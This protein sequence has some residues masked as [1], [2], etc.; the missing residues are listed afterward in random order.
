MLV[1]FRGAMQDALMASTAT[2]TPSSAVDPIFPNYTT[3]TAYNLV[4]SDFV[5]G[6]FDVLM[7]FIEDARDRLRDGVIEERSN[8]GRELIVGHPH[9]SKYDRERQQCKN[10]VSGM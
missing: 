5:N 1:L 10:R 6:V 3:P 8:N 9:W 4:A 2:A 7:Y